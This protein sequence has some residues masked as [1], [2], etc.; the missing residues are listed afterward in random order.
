[1]V[2]RVFMVSP[3]GIES[4]EH[5]HKDVIRLKCVPHLATIKSRVTEAAS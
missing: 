1:M 5:V 3:F 4:A 2:D